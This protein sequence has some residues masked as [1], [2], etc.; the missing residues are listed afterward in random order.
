MSEPLVPSAGGNRR[1]LAPAGLPGIRLLLTSLILAYLLPCV[2]G[3]ALLLVHEYRGSRSDLER[4]TQQ[5]ARALVQAVDN[6]LLRVQSIGQV[7]ATSAVLASGDLAAFHQRAREAVAATGLATNVALITGDMRQV[8][9]TAADYGPALPAPPDP[10]STRRVF[11][12]GQP[13]FSDLHTSEVLKHP[14]VGVEIPV[15]RG[16]RMAYALRVGMLAQQLDAVLRTQAL[17]PDWVAGVFDSTGTI[18]ARTHAAEQ[19]VGHQA[20]AQLLQAMNTARA[21]TVEVITKEGIPVTSSF[22]CS[23]V[24]KWCVAI[25][26]PRQSLLGG[27]TRTL[28]MLAAGATLLLVLGAVL[29]RRVGHR[30]SRSVETLTA[31]AAALGRGDAVAVPD[32]SVREAAEVAAAL[33]QAT[34]LLQERAALVRRRDAQLADAQLLA[35]LGTWSWDAATQEFRASESLCRL[36]GHDDGLSEWQM[37][38]AFPAAS[39]QQL[40]A[41]V[42][43]A[44]STGTGLDMELSAQHASG[45]L[46][47]L[48]A[49]SSVVSDTAGQTLALHGTMQDI[50]ERK[51]AEQ[52]LLR[53]HQ[54]LSVA[55]RAARAGL[56]EWDLASGE[57]GWSDE[58][59]LLFGLDPR[60]DRAS[61]DAWQ[62][63]VHADD[64]KQA[65][66]ALAAAVQQRRAL[67]LS[68]RIVPSAGDER[69]I[70]VFGDVIADSAGQGLRMSGMCID[71]TDWHRA[72]RALADLSATLDLAPVIVRDFDGTIRHWSQGCEQLYGW[73]AVE[74]VGRNVHELLRTVFPLPRTQLD[75]TLQREG[76]WTGELHH[77]TRDG[78][79]L[80][81]VAR[82]VLRRDAQGRALAV[83][84]AVADVTAARE[85]QAELAQLNATLEQRVQ[86]RTQEL[87]AMRDAAEAA[88]RAKSAFLANM[89]HEIRTPMNAIIGF[90]HLLMRD[91]TGGQ[92][93]Q[94]LQTV[95]QA[96]QHLLQILNDILDLSKIEAGKMVLEDAEF[97]LDAI[98]SRIVGLVREPAAAKELELVLDTDALPQR[99]RGD[100]T[101]LSQ[102][103]LNLL[104]NAVK[105]TARGWVRVRAELLRDDAAQVMARFEVSDSG[106]GIAPERLGALFTAFEQ[107]DASTTRRH[108]G[109]GLG[110]ALTRHI[111]QLMGGDVGVQSAPG[112]GSSFWF[113][114]CLGRAADAAHVIMPIRLQGLRAL[115]VDDLSA[116]RSALVEQLWGLSLKAVAADSGQAAVRLAQEARASG[117]SFDVLLIDWRMPAMDGIA[118]LAQL[119]RTLASPPRCSILVTALDEAHLQEQA[120]VAGFQAVLL[121]PVTAS[122]LHD[123]LVRLLQS[124]PDP[125]QTRPVAGSHTLQALKSRHAGARVLLAEDN[126]VNQELAVTLL[127][128]ADLEVVVAEDGQRAVELA[129]AQGFDAILMDMQM[130]RMDGLTATAAIRAKRGPGVPIIAMTANAFADDRQACLAAGMNDFLTKPV[131]LETLYATLQRWLVQREAS[132]GNGP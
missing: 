87:A 62:A 58:L 38:T 117:E 5:T 59:F 46:L 26:I 109:T 29:A 36:L 70:D 77:T 21:G 24:T 61:I 27:L 25:G 103:L 40:L 14:M 42:R 130:P 69:W 44:A 19:F 128:A 106:E 71:A 101:R 91:A 95:E 79:V 72:E 35:R 116:A 54:R 7:L 124:A 4:D 122:A 86:L 34:E 89:S 100:P 56:W 8:L 37:E 63:V 127:R 11:A 20:G 80:V 57:L 13:V 99:L 22:S 75:A 73:R 12:R 118:T 96:A 74:A 132:A 83:A 81:V 48:H 1:A 16:G 17:P 90:T 125:A 10:D 3:A 9:N 97:E 47:W 49:K 65:L 126:A 23:P 32:V 51:A 120:R 55:Q 112:Q 6:Q 50:S 115:V 43:Q 31:A 84:E 129:L 105:F 15:V 66:D 123:T 67:K 93:L 76:K 104:S 2:L 94:R 107:A 108:G 45:P 111:A 82:K 88:T 131:V 78:R 102:A 68:Y 98:L 114:A 110:L 119:H 52:A 28:S 64:R 60:S 41:A 53:A 113:T 39:W 33:A 85:A 121:K 92:Q 18:L 30:I